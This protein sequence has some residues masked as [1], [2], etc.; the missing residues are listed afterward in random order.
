[1]YLKTLTIKG[2][3][4][5]AS[6]TKLQFEPGITAI[7]GPNGSGKSNIVDA[8]SWV[9]GEQGAKSLRGGKMEDVIFAGTA[10]RAPLGRAEVSL[11]IDNTDGA[12]PIDY[13]EVTISRTLFRSGGSEYAI[14]GT[15]ARLL[16]VQELLSDT[17]MG[18]EMHVIVG[19][20]Q[21]DQILQAT[22][23]QRRGFIEEAAGVLKHRRRREKATRKLEATQT[24]LDRLNDLVSEIRRQ[25]KPL[26]RQAEVARR[27]AVVQAEL[28]DAKARL[29]ADDMQQAIEGLEADL[30][31]E[32]LM[33]ER[34]GRAESNLA[35]ARQAEADAEQRL[36]TIH[37][38]L[39]A[40]QETWY[41]LSG[42]RERVS[43]TLSIAGERM[44]MGA[45]R[46][47]V[48][49]GR[50]PEDLENEAASIRQQ[51]AALSEDVR[52]AEQALVAAGSRREELE[53]QL[54]QAEKAFASQLRAIADRREGLARLLGQANGLRSRLEAGD[55]EDAR[56]VARRDEAI[57]RAD[58][59]DAEF[60]RL[61]AQ[62]ASLGAGE[63]N[64]D[65][66]WERAEQQRSEAHADV[67][68]LQTREAEA[69][70]EL[71]AVRAKVEGLAVALERRDG[72][73]AL[74]END[75]LAGLDG[76]LAAQLEVP[77]AWQAAVAA[78][79]GNA[80]D[81][82]VAD[83]IS[84]AIEAIDYLKVGD[85]G[86]A[87]L[88]IAADED[89]DEAWP[90]LPDGASWAIDVISTKA[91]L[92]GALR[93]RL[94]KVALVE[95]LVAAQQL[96]NQHPDVTAVTAAG[97]IL[98]P[99]FVQG[100]SEGKPSIL[101]IEAAVRQAQDEAE[102]LDHQLQRIKFE[103]ASANA[104]LEAADQAA[105]AALEAL[106]ESDAQM[107]ALAEQLGASGQTSRTSR[108]EAE[109]LDQ[110]LT[111]AQAGRERDRDALGELEERI[112]A[113]EGEGE[114]AEPDP[115]ERDDLANQARLARAAEMEA[116]LALRTAEER[117]RSVA[118]RADSLLRAAQHERAARAKA[119]ARLERLRR[120]AEI[121]AAV[122][123]AAGWLA[124]RVD[125]ARSAAGA[126]RAEIEQRRLAA[127]AELGH[128]RANSRQLAASLESIVAGAHKDE[129]ARIEMKLRVEQ[130][131]ER[132]LSELGLDPEV[133]VDEYGP[134]QL[135]PVLVDESGAAI[136]PESDEQPEPVAYDRAAQTERLR[137]ATRDLELLGKVNPLA[138]EEFDALNERHA[139]LAE[140]L[141][142]L[143]QTRK[144]LV[145]LI[146]D[147]DARVQ[148]VFASAYQD[149][150]K[151]FAEV[152]TRL[153]PGGE[154]RLIL[155][156]PG[157][158]LTTGIDIEARPAGKKVKRLSLLS[159]GERS[160]VAVAFLL[161]LFIA[162]PSPFYI[163]DEVEA[164]LDDVNL[165]R[166]LDVYQELRKNSQLLIITH[167]KRTMEI[168]DSLYGVTM[169]GDGVSTVI[170]QR[171]AEA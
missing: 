159:G 147:V 43:T 102:A 77:Q 117:V 68:S 69:V 162:R 161:S 27:A 142:D 12:L 7:V 134:E 36:A 121:A 22:P 73:G 50:D 136:D 1:M 28:R 70:R 124:E 155:T 153:F 120:E 54:G 80:G 59:A 57:A 151:T 94:H 56:L 52:A 35:E 32:K 148:E 146:E 58:E 103:L 169:R 128:A 165:G 137:K 99:W 157:D 19:Q 26:G 23:E 95:D 38:Q 139:F 163:L 16:D 20:G 79:L 108:A 127:E 141:D 86:R 48:Q 29:L 45:E 138:L 42:L 10:G 107:A 125:Q 171:L 83:E 61:E 4:S 89:V 100:G 72:T 53:A 85:L 37:P 123:E 167:Q 66:A 101:Q 34:R 44:R 87:G 116:R 84:S 132:A 149:I 41:G 13:T 5:F 47:A 105:A 76:A 33:L 75:E 64:L 15:A 39:A 74:L 135:I 51:E 113:A 126:E 49:Q 8:L 166:L 152:F 106:N 154:G 60:T 14:N 11:T 122:H 6:A 91:Q 143:K 160:L 90:E 18:R 168:A 104:D 82:V 40:A 131:T 98:S 25:L 93:A 164:A 92:L 144:D 109:R 150:E 115:A 114:L 97:D 65:E 130:L 46:Q 81:A 55:E 67:E 17:G 21:L 9:M 30:A 111:A 63:S 78:A 62:L 140:Q 2:F 24:N 3:K 110:A 158:M 145:E 118:G 170:S 156:D 71:A 88:L 96:V 31:D 119:Q 133:L 112:A 129:M